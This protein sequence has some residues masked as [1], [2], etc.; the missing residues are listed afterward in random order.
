M[1]RLSPC[2]PLSVFPPLT[3]LVPDHLVEELHVV[4]L[5]RRGAELDCCPG[6][7]IHLPGDVVRHK[8]S[9]FDRRLEWLDM[10]LQQRNDRPQPELRVSQKSEQQLHVA[11][12]RAAS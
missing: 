3:S 12:A 8:W 5:I 6:M 7:Q 4:V 11:V 10:V 9:P 2:L 1:D